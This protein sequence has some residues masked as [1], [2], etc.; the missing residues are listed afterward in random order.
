MFCRN[1]D[2]EASKIYNLNIS[3]TYLNW[4]TGKD[5]ALALHRLQQKGCK[6]EHLLTS[7][8]AEHDRVSMHGLRRTLLQRQLQS[9]GIPYSTMELPEEPSMETYEILMKQAVEQLQADGFTKSAF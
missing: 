1:I 4:S 3:R 2:S 9:V 5:S 7:V 8:H 6:V